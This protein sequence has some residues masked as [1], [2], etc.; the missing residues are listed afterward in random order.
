VSDRFR[1]VDTRIEGLVLIEPTVHPDDRGFFF[2][3]YRRNEYEPLGIEVEFVQDNHSRSV[4]GT[5]R[6]LHF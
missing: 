4:R 5:I 3:T 6:A 1:R 2:E